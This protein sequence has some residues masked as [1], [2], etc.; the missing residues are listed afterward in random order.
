MVFLCV[1]VGGSKFILIP[2]NAVID[3]IHLCVKYIFVE[4]LLS[5]SGAIHV[6]GTIRTHTE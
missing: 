1:L 4:S 5:R 2:K 6:L 3:S